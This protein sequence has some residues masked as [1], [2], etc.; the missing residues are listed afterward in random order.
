MRA[1]GRAGRREGD[2][3]VGESVWGRNEE[4]ARKGR[5]GKLGVVGWCT[6][7]DE[8]ARIHYSTCA[9]MC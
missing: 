8:T 6:T 3:G 2:R 5:G 4:V 7:R 9:T 1:G